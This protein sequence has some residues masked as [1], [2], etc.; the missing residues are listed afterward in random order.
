MSYLATDA[1]KTMGDQEIDSQL[2]TFVLA[3][4]GTTASTIFWLL[5]ELS[6][7]P[8]DQI[9]VREEIVTTNFKAPG[10]LT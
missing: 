5:Y 1:K 4:I 10:T 6:R 9:K 2:G 3:A 8:E 7:H